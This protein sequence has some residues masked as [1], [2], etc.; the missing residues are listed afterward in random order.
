M[1]MVLSE[2]RDTLVTV[3]EL[4]KLTHIP[5]SWWYAAAERQAVPSFKV[6]KYRRFSLP[7]VLRWLEARAE[8]P[9]APVKAAA[10][11]A[12]GRS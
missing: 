10:G 5:E 4:A 9:E 3:H 7:A 2:E 12:G 11:R 8:G 6:G 1:P